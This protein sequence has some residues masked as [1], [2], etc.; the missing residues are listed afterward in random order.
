MRELPPV[1]GAG[2]DGCV[3]REMAFIVERVQGGGGVQVAFL[4]Y[5]RHSSNIRRF[6]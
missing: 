6:S 4:E 1:C 2:R 3:G 5:L